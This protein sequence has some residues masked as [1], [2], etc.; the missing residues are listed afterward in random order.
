VEAWLQKDP[1]PRFEKYLMKN[2]LMTTDEL[3]QIED[4]VDAEIQEALDFAFASDYPALETSVQDIY[5]DI[6]EEARSR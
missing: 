1:I 6:V 3:K 2:K 4:E 5:S